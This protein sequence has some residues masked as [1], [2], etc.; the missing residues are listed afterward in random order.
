[1][2]ELPEIE[3]YV[4]H[5]RD[6]VVGQRITGTEIT[7]P[8]TINVLPEEFKAE[9]TGRTITG[10][11]RRA[12]ILVMILD[13]GASL[14]VHFM[15]EGYMLLLAPGEEPREKPQVVLGLETGERLAFFRLLLGWMHL[16]EGIDPAAMPELQRLGIEPLSPDFTPDALWQL[17]QG[18][19]GRLKPLLIDQEFIAGIGSSYADEIL[20]RAGL[21]PDRLA[22]S[23][24]PEEAI[25]FHSAIQ[26]TLGRAIELGGAEERPLFAGDAVTG[27]FSGEY[28]VYDREGQP[29]HTCGQPIGEAR[30]GGRRSFFCSRCQK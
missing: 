27:H 25:R 10:A 14:L 7:R 11:R 29:C 13:S 9:V 2:P 26:Q 18:R 5:L 30:V 23:L 20:F 15:V 21:L 4:R 12:K 6:R 8:R 19:R 28:M 22:Q 24:S 3:T 17:L 1:M 16:V